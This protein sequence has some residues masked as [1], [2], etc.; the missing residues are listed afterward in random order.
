MTPREKLA[1]STDAQ[2]KAV[3]ACNLAS[4]AYLGKDV[5]VL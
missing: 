1:S 2:I 3:G 4:S 5:K